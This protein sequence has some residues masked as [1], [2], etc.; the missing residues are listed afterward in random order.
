[1]VVDPEGSAFL[2]GWEQDSSEVTTDTP[3]RIEGIGRN[4]IEPSFVGGVI[5]EMLRVPDAASIAAMRWCSEWTGRMVGAST[6]TNLWGVLHVIAR[7]RGAGETGSVVTL[8]CDHGDRYDDTY[9][10]DDWLR[11]QGI[12][13]AGYATA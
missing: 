13:I 10:N 11:Q 7:M 9:Y 6:G 5:D 3:S 4:R 12:E 1:A 8:L 2:G